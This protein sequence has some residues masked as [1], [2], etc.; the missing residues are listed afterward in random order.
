M[1]CPLDFIPSRK[2]WRVVSGPSLADSEFANCTKAIEG[3]E[4]ALGRC[5]KMALYSCETDEA[6]AAAYSQGRLD[7]A[8]E[9]MWDLISENTIGD[10][11]AT[12]VGQDTGGAMMCAV[13][14]RQGSYGAAVL[15][16][17]NV[18]KYHVKDATDWAVAIRGK[19]VP[20][21]FLRSVLLP[22][23]V[24]VAVFAGAIGG[25]GWLVSKCKR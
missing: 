5:V 25:L 3:V 14:F 9:S 22:T 12:Y 23:V 20:T 19:M 18:G 11:S 24:G 8:S 1:K 6:A 16:T 21:Q 15:A 17:N 2:G 13:V 4:Y 10:A 7:L